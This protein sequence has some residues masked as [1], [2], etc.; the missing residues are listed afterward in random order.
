MLIK[1]HPLY[2][3]L[4]FS[5]SA[6]AAESRTVAGQMQQIPPALPTENSIPNVEVRRESPPVVPK[7][8]NVKIIV[9]RLNVI[10]SQAYSEAVL[11][12]VRDMP[13]L[14]SVL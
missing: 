14:R 10:G 1:K 9:K 7:V 11:I 13:N 4:T 2:V 5:L 8:E 6:I 12:A 3:L